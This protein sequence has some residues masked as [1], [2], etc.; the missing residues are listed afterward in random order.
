M[1]LH[2]I[3]RHLN[4]FRKLEFDQLFILESYWSKEYLCKISYLCTSISTNPFCYHFTRFFCS[5]IIF[6]IKIDRKYS[7]QIPTPLTIQCEHVYQLQLCSELC[8]HM[9]N[10]VQFRGKN[11]NIFGVWF[12]RKLEDYEYR[13]IF[14]IEKCL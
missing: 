11:L 9:M 2:S 4:Y 14:H 7:K 3:T 5:Y 13:V 8:I 12:I 10:A 6:I 1:F